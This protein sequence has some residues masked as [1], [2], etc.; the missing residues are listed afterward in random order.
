M[1]QIHGHCVC[2]A[3]EI[4]IKEYGNFALPK[5]RNNLAD[6]EWLALTNRPEIRV[7]DTFTKA[8]DL[9]IAVKEPR[10]ETN[11]WWSVA[12]M[13]AALLRNEKA[14]SPF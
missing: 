11:L 3:V 2:G 10:R 7:H 5:L 9:K 13:Y 1:N 6:L 12:E 4:V 8:E 14:K